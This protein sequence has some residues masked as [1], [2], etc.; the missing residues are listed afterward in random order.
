MNLPSVQN[1]DEHKPL[2]ADGPTVPVL[3]GDMLLMPPRRAWQV[4]VVDD[5]ESVH[6]VVRLSLRGLTVEARPV[7]LLEAR[8]AAEARAILAMHRDIAVMLLDV[9]ME[10]DDAGLKLVDHVR[11]TLNNHVIRIVLSTGQPGAA[12]EETVM[13]ERDVNGYLS[14]SDLSAQ[15]LRTAV[16]GAIRSYHDVATIARQSLLMECVARM[17]GRYVENQAPIAVAQAMLGDM[18]HAFDGA[19]GTI[20]VRY[21]ART[22][23]HVL[24]T[25]EPLEGE[26]LASLLRNRI[27]AALIDAEKSG[28]LGLRRAPFSVADLDVPVE[29][30]ET[31]LLP[32]HI[33]NHVLGATW[34]AVP[35]QVQTTPDAVFLALTRAVAN[36]LKALEDAA[37]RRLAEE[38]RDASHRWLTQVTA[39]VPDGLLVEESTGQI[40]LVNTRFCEM[41]GIDAPP[42]ALIGLDCKLAA[43]AAAEKFVNADQF[44]PRVQEIIAKREPVTAEALEMIDGR[45]LERDFVPLVVN[46][47]PATIWRYHDITAAKRTQEALFASQSRYATLFHASSDA[48]LILNASGTV[49]DANESSG[50]LLEIAHQHLLSMKFRDL[51][52]LPVSCGRE[53]LAELQMGQPVLFE[54]RLRRPN[55]GQFPAEIR[56]NLV[57]VEGEQLVEVN[58]RDITARQ[59]Q[60][61]ALLSAKT[62][63]DAASAAKSQFLAVMSHE[64]RT[65]INAVLGAS[66]LLRGSDLR[67]SQRELAEIVH[68]SSEVLLTLINDLLDFSKIEAAQMELDSEP[69]DLATLAES[70][71]DIVRVRASARGLTL[72]C[73]IDGRLPARV[74]GDANRIRQIAMNLLSNAIKFTEVGS[75]SF[76]IRVRERATESVSLEIV[77]EDSG[78][79]IPPDQRDN[80]FGAFVQGENSIFRRFGG[81]GLGLSIVRSL[82]ELMGG[83]IAVRS[84]PQS[85]TTMTVRLTLPTPA[86]VKT[87]VGMWRGSTPPKGTVLLVMEALDQ[88]AAIVQ[89]LTDW[90]LDVVVAGNG[91]E[92]LDRLSGVD[93]HYRCVVV[94]DLLPDMDGEEVITAV[95]AIQSSA[96]LPVILAAA[97]Q[98]SETDERNV[99]KLA[100]PFHRSRLR[101]GIA[102][103]LGL[104]DSD[105]LEV[106]RV[107]PAQGEPGAG[108]VLVAEDNPENA[109][110]L[111]HTLMGTGYT[112]DEVADGE[113]A[114]AAVMANLYGLVLMDLDM[115]ALDGISATQR[116]RDWEKTLG[117]PQTPIVAVTAH[118]LRSIRDR[119]LA[120][121]MNDY[122]SKPLRRKRVLDMTANWLD[123][124]PFVLLADDDHSTRTVLRSWLRA[125]KNLRSLVVG[126]G[127]ELLDAFTRHPVAVVLLDMQMSGL[128][129]YQTVEQLRRMPGGD[130]VPVIAMTGNN[131]RGDESRCRQAGCTDFVAKPFTR[132]I[133][134]AAIDK[135]LTRP[136]AS[137]SVPTFWPKSRSMTPMAKPSGG[138]PLAKPMMR[139][140]VSPDVAD[141]V[142]EF[143]EAQQQTANSIRAAL[144]KSDFAQIAILGHNLRGI[145]ATMGFNPL[146]Q[147]AGEI[148]RAGLQR[149]PG[150]VVNALKTLDFLLSA[151]T[152]VTQC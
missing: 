61:E 138:S 9:V 111:R 83:Q 126:D 147:T 16:A 97:L 54:D 116:I 127:Q 134:L 53:A 19:A 34:M 115:P 38:S 102:Q 72:Q 58:L 149:A 12:P 84:E 80:I 150:D 75:V 7:D 89:I 45:W 37:L 60:Q 52:A 85:G 100:K 137:L 124:R 135:Y 142:P 132:E 151:A 30:A 78:I 125:E 121:G 95:R 42:E 77:V 17:Q 35:D 98:A 10:T 31:W 141:L 112:V 39:N 152:E 101:L 119:C 36:L 113:A 73:T 106:L 129:G 114:V 148:E 66:E 27:E 23:M 48:I 49:V 70:V 145:S 92:T 131:G 18:L 118:A 68:G 146:A 44:V 74:V 71:V 91:A 25:T 50:V 136:K 51:F 59:Q 139:I 103:A 1:L 29:F 96:H 109:I 57:T 6:A 24:A 32:L 65:P 143:L 62:A 69:F 33:G 3:P 11:H 67:R 144:K 110:L 2:F 47:K 8:S 22:Q 21:G 76:A 26:P 107:L 122:M 13:T 5:D 14:K 41:F 108:R 105:G 28:E 104:K 120:A 15:R 4:L 79:G 90:G 43:D 99:I 128:N 88:R 130:R 94:D 123:T 86:D 20:L 81:S 93:L 55:A 40:K 82:V 117:R 133:V 46:N 63:A 56:A 64:I 140:A 87:T